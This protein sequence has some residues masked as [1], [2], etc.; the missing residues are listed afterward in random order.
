[1]AFGR[2]D[3]GADPGI[4]NKAVTV[5]GHTMTVVG[6]ASP[7]FSGLM[8]DDPPALYVPV[9]MQSEMMPGRNDLENRRASWLNVM[10]RLK[11]GLIAISSGILFGLA[12]ALQTAAPALAETLKQQ[13]SSVAGGAI[14]VRYRKALVVAQVALSL[15][16]LLGA[17]L[18]LRSVQNL[19]SIELGFK[20]DHL[21][22]F[23]VDPS[24]NGYDES[25]GIA[26][27][28]RLLAQIAALPGVRGASIAQTPLLSGGNWKSGISIPGREP[29]D[30][31]PT[32][33]SDVIG[34]GY[35][36]MCVEA[37]VRICAGGDQ[38]CSSLPRQPK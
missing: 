31:D 17:G 29:K 38:Q 2:G 25:R 14:Q 30:T 8:I 33:N 7:A 4:L 24:L 26:L 35:F 9:T 34:A 6:V 10:A 3:S 20:A 19:K 11:A 5:S 18:F 32:P 1:M 15:L 23:S 27:Y 28:D 36:S 12:P 21:I 16:L 22:S 13:T 37:H